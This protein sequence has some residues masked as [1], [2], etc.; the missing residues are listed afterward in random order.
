MV[1]NP[2]SEHQAETTAYFVWDEGKW[3]RETDYDHG[4]DGVCQAKR[5]KN[6]TSSHTTRK[7]ELEFCKE[8]AVRLGL[9]W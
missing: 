9:E 6:P 8:C 1:E 2:Y 5:I 3:V 7:Y 4:N